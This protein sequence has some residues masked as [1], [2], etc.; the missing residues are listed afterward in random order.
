MNATEPATDLRVLVVD[1]E[2]GISLSLGVCLEAMGCSVVRAESAD[3]ACAA[4]DRTRF[5]LAFVDLRLGAADGLE[6]LSL[7]RA[8]DPDTT[9]VVMTAYASVDRAVEAMR[10]GAWDFVAKPFTPDQVRQAVARAAERRRLLARV[11]DLEGRL[12]TAAPDPAEESACPAFRAVIETLRRAA[13]SDAPVLLRGESGTG[14]SSLARIVHDRSRRAA[15]PFA[16]VNCPTLTA[17]LLAA[18]LFGHARG[19][20]TGAVQDR[21]GRVETAD[22]GTLF[23]DEV[24]EIPPHLQAKLLRFAQDR[25]YERVGDP[26]TRRADVRIVAATNRDLD[27]EVAAGRFREDLLYRLNVVDVTVPA[28]RDRPEDVIPLAERF[29]AFFARAAGRPRMV[30]TDSARATLERHRWPGNVRE[31]RNAMERVAILWTA[32]EVPAEALP[33]RLRGAAAPTPQ[34]GGEFT[35]EQIEREHL[36]RVLA[37]HPKPE[38]AARVLGIDPSTLWRK[39]RRLAAPPPA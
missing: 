30:L 32:D 3:A 17:E 14:K 8:K 15:R 2:P 16:V 25:E 12:A 28:L 4:A 31:L 26:A 34:V 18:E 6:V 22:G 9:M 36:V 35:I 38:E 21:P 7:L 37:R 39:R 27:A 10:R 13:S 23:L 19:A 20:F 11:A 24:A 1:D 29:L 33:E 5:D